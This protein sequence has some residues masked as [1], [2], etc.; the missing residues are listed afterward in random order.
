MTAAE[1]D[2]ALAEHD[3]QERE[4]AFDEAA[5]ALAWAAEHGPDPIAY[6]LANNPHRSTEPIRID[7]PEEET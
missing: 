6:V 3:R 5:Q 7:T 4:K 1:F 2:A